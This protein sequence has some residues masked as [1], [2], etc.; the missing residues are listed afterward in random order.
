MDTGSFQGVEVAGAWR[1]PPTTSS[2]EVKE[3]VDL[4]FYS[5]LGLRG[6]F[7]GEL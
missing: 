3:R 5:F 2:A 6:L 7:K 1:S 4:Y